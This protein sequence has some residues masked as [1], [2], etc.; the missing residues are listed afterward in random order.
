MK[1]KEFRVFYR[2]IATTDDMASPVHSKRIKDAE[3]EIKLE[4][5]INSNNS[6]KNQS[7]GGTPS[8]QAEGAIAEH[9]LSSKSDNTMTFYKKIKAWFE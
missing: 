7:D 3:E 1:Q 6:I 9:S 4:A 2:L 8:K 5:D